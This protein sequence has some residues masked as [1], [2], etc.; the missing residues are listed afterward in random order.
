MPVAD[1]RRCRTLRGQPVG[2]GSNGRETHIH[3]HSANVPHFSKLACTILIAAASYRRKI[4]I[5]TR[6]AP[7]LALFPA[8]AAILRAPKDSEE[9][10]FFGARKIAAGAGN[11]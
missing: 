5:S 2:A 7:A 6:C 11:S 9:M 3:W 4:M 8:P 10:T 1:R